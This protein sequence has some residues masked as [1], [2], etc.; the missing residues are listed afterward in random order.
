MVEAIA[1]FDPWRPYKPCAGPGA[2]AK[3]GG[4]G[5]V[6]AARVRRRLAMRGPGIAETLEGRMPWTGALN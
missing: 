4:A 5:T 3:P 6:Q 1:R 2:A